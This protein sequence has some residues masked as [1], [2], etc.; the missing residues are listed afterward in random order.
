MANSCFITIVCSSPQDTAL[1]KQWSAAV[2]V[3]TVVPAAAAAAV[4]VVVVAAVAAAL[5]LS[6]A[7]QAAP[8]D[9]QQM[10]V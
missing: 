4:V 6:T 9:L 8:T 1:V 7:S 10:T 5:S 3:R 2:V